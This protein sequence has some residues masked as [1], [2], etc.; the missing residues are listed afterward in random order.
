MYATILRG[1]VVQENWSILEH[2]YE[3]LSKDPPEGLTQSF[4][5][6]GKEQS[7]L[8][9]VIS[10]W[11]NEEMYEKSKESQKTMACEMMFCAAGTVPERICFKVRRW[12]ELV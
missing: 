8:W 11:K 7:S 4:L 10:L 2:Q 6:Q 9:Q 12:Y 1:L 3:K 5:I